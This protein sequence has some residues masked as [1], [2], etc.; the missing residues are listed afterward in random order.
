MTDIQCT[1]KMK[2]N[3]T[4]FQKY[5]EKAIGKLTEKCV[6]AFRDTKDDISRIQ[7]MYDVAKQIPLAAAND[8]D[9]DYKVAEERKN[10]GN[11]LFAKKDYAN[12]IRCYNEGIIRCPQESGG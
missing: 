7:L 9:K 4:D 5:C 2:S 3:I 1:C 12:A 11:K 10:D 8:N 6:D